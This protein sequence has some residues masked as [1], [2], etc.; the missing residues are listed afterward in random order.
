MMASSDIGRGADRLQLRAARAGERREVGAARRSAAVWSSWRHVAES[1][2]VTRSRPASRSSRAGSCA[3]VVERPRR[4][5]HSSQPSMA[6]RVPTSGRPRCGGR[7]RRARPSC[8]GP[9][10]NT[11]ATAVE[12]TGADATRG[13]RPDVGSRRARRLAVDAGP[14]MTT[15][16]RAPP[17]ASGRTRATQRL[18]R[19]PSPTPARDTE[20]RPGPR[21]LD[22][23][24]PAVGRDA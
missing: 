4:H 17:S 16:C 23:A 1:C 11:A 9:H 14:A 3:H 18:P 24:A 13:Q 12:V 22:D 15:P 2:V 5:R 20:R 6:A 7:S 19:G 21:A 10:L 8:A